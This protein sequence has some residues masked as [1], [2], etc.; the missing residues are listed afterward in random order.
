MSKLSDKY[1]SAALDTD[2]VDNAVSSVTV[3]TRVPDLLYAK[4]SSNTTV[5][6]SYYWP[7][8]TEYILQGDITNTSGS[9]V[10]LKA[11]RT[12]RLTADLMF[13]SVNTQKVYFYNYTTSSTISIQAI[14]YQQSTSYS[15]TNTGS[16]ECLYTVG[17]TDENVAV[18]FTASATLYSAYSSILVQEVPNQILD[19]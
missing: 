5:A 10:T 4:P 8:G 17:D 2:Y 11:G 7:F 14:E 18:R 19:S 9:Y 12:Y 1:K 6:N 16:L 3:S 15:Y 13:A